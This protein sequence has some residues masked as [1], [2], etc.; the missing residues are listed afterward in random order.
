MVRP[1][2]EGATGAC[3]DSASL[4]I[5]QSD[6]YQRYVYCCMCSIAP[7]NMWRMTTDKLLISDMMLFKIYLKEVGFAQ[8]PVAL[9]RV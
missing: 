4:A 3:R 9:V 2:F 5:F 6:R 7:R 1:R 8:G